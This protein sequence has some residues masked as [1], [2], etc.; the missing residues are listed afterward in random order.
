MRRMQINIKYWFKFIKGENLKFISHLDLLRA[1]ERAIRRSN[2]PVIY[3]QG[4]N[5][6]QKL[7]FAL[8]LPLGVSSVSEYGEILLSRNILTDEIKEKLNESLPE[9]LAIKEVVRVN[10]ELPTLMSIV[11]LSEYKLISINEIDKNKIENILASK[12]ITYKKKT[13]NK[14]QEI[15]LKDYIYDVKIDKNIVDV[16]LK[17]GSRGH[18]KPAEFIEAIFNQDIT[19]FNIM[20]NEIYTELNNKI[21][22]PFQY[23][24]LKMNFAIA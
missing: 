17:S 10:C 9:G 1:Y 24:A 22:S 15:N 12:I 6:R 3:S 23:A 20:R 5:P 8:P 16:F 13:K 21:M 11:T 2:I 19:N 7:S 18:I 4:F 14:E